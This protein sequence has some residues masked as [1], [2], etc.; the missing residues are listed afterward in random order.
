[1][2]K[3]LIAFLVILPLALLA[4]GCGSKG[5]SGS[6][7]TPAPSATPASIVP[8][9]FS[10]TSLETGAPVSAATIQVN[11][12]GGQPTGADGTVMVPA[13]SGQPIDITSPN[14]FTRQSQLRD[15]HQYN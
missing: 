4:L 12:Q 1:M 15:D 9:R 3:R 11:G 7:P 8:T 5:P 6:T 2:Q 13:A 14:F 10:V